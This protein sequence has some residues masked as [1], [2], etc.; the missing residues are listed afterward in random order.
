MDRT[1]VIVIALCV[2]LII[3]WTA[4]RDR[5]FPPVAVPPEPTNAP[6]QVVTGAAPPTNGVPPTVL[7][8]PAQPMLAINT[9]VPETLVEVTNSDAHYTFTSRG[10]GLKL[11]ELLHYKETVG[12][13][14]TKTPE[15]DYALLNAYTPAPTLAL[16]DG[17][18]VQGDGEFHLTPTATGV[19]AEKTLTNGL[20]IVKNFQI[21]T[22]YLVLATIQL[23]NR[24]GQALNLP[25]TDWFIGTASPMNNQDKATTIGTMWYDGN[26]SHDEMGARIFATSGFACTPRVPPVEFRAG[27]NNVVWAGVHNQY[28]A[29]VAM[30]H[31]PAAQVVMRKIELPEPSAEEIQA[32]FRVVRAP[33][34]YPSSLVY[35]AVTLG[36]HQVL[37]KHIALY[38]GPKE[39][40]TLATVSSLYSN[41]VD[42]VMG[43][44]F[45]GFF[46][47]ALL[48]GMNWLHRSLLLPYGWAIVGITL[49]IKLVFWPLTQ[50]STRSAKRMQVLQPQIKALQDKYK[51]DPVQAQRKMMEFWKE[52][53]INPMSGCLPTLIQMPV[54]F[55]FYYMIG[56]AIELRGQPWLWV[57]DLSRPD[58]LFLIPG[59]NFPFNLLP[60]LMGATMLWQSHL[61]PPSP[62]MDQTQAKMMRY[63]PLMFL[64]FLYNYSAGLTLYW[65][66]NNLLSVVQTKL[67]RS[68]PEPPTGPAA[69]PVLTRVQKRRK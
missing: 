12:T 8:A 3:L 51:D 59:M 9:N 48:L 37:E 31:E 43:F 66:I 55:G 54:F 27:S 57:R 36:P 18:A 6:A 28:F 56:S 25:A 20:T 63:M 23:T 46:S 29:L 22:D 64:V 40:T 16:L 26:K 69:G 30:P 4:F 50:A 47:K 15:H 68:R 44:G 45:W 65:T 11:I 41:D 62:G 53:K 2:L 13:H 5:L 17:G 1:S 10:G 39:Y 34:G 67:I 61:T 21:S 38:A 24:S 49:M 52:H 7:Q 14:A 42:A 32:D 60:L 58:T 33:V 19:V 35:P